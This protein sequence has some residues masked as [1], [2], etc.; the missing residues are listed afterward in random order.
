MLSFAVFYF[1][2]VNGAV[3]L[4]LWLV[5]GEI[6]AYRISCVRYGEWVRI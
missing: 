6:R 1:K 5:L 4:G 2:D 3:V